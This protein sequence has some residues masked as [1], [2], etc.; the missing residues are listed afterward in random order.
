ML[1]SAAV[2]AAG[3]VAGGRRARFGVEVYERELERYGGPEATTLA[4]TL[5]CADSAAT[6]ELLRRLR[7]E[8]GR[9]DRTELAVL[10][11]DDLLDSL[12]MDLEA[13]ARW[14]AG[15]DRSPAGGPEYRERKERLRR[16]L[17]GTDGALGEAHA[18]VVATLAER[19]RAVAPVA[20]HLA[21]L[22]GAGELTRPLP[23][24][25]GSYV[26]LHCS[27]LLGPEADGE[28]LV[29]GLLRRTLSSLVAAP[30]PVAR[31]R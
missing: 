1:P 15:E 17:A 18:G 30:L 13:R 11:V 3:L 2:W 9:L 23:D 19:R 24:P 28:R 27:R 29:L 31:V 16:L 20:T 12:G 8:A 26:H 21:A 14:C 4:E 22:A 10:S 5:F 7:A 25:A 6:A